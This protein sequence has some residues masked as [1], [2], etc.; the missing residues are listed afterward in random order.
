MPDYW[1]ELISLFSFENDVD[2]RNR[3]MVINTNSLVGV[4]FKD[5]VSSMEFFA[6]SGHK[7]SVELFLK[8]PQEILEETKRMLVEMTMKTLTVYLKHMDST[9]T[10][11]DIISFLAG[12]YS[13][14]DPVFLRTQSINSIYMKDE[15]IP[16][17][18]ESAFIG[19]VQVLKEVV[20]N[21]QSGNSS[22]IDET[23]KYFTVQMI[24]FAFNS[25]MSNYK[26][27]SKTIGENNSYQF[28]LPEID[29]TKDIPVNKMQLF[30]WQ[31]TEHQGQ[32][33]KIEELS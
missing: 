33:L 21:I 17:I 14:F 20:S 13:F 31:I 10:R 16:N 4:D 18:P 1:Q 2:F 7:D 22:F 24:E 3:V 9:E 28:G 26:D 15:I 5:E 32:C 25:V 29:P 27:T 19:L 8:D 11:I 6:G 30:K 23:E 12:I